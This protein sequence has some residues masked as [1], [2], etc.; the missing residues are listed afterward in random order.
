MERVYG[1][2]VVP[3]RTQQVAQNEARTAG[4]RRE[5]L[6]SRRG[7]CDVTGVRRQSAVQQQAHIL[8]LLRSAADGHLRGQTIAVKL[9]K[10]RMRWGCP[11]ANARKQTKIRDRI[12]VATNSVRKT[13]QKTAGVGLRAGGH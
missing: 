8:E 6:P 1:A 9:R 3:E 2:A 10:L 5:D 4:G 7:A 11:G 12:R 13:L